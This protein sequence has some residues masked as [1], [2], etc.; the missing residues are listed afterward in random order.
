M[1]ERSAVAAWDSFGNS[2]ALGRSCSCRTS[3]A[4]GE[5]VLA[6]FKACHSLG[7]AAGTQRCRIK[8]ERQV[9]GGRSSNRT[10][11]RWKMKTQKGAKSKAAVSRH[12]NPPGGGTTLCLPA[13]GCPRS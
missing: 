7:N 8:R 10:D 12:A 11:A 2:L 1:D 9:K 4:S 6:A 5:A 3:Y 13:I